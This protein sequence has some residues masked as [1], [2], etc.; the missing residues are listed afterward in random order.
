MLD[1]AGSEG[2]DWGE[3]VLE[4]LSF[5]DGSRVG[6]WEGSGRWSVAW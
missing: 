3:G 4:W 5:W 1:P 6:G 2:E